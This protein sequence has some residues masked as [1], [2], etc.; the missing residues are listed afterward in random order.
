MPPPGSIAAQ[1]QPPPAAERREWPGPQEAPPRNKREERRSL[2]RALKRT[3]AEE[4]AEAK[5][6]AAAAA[7]QA[8]GDAEAEAAAGADA[9][10]SQAESAAA[11]V[12]MDAS[13]EGEAVG[14]AGGEGAA[15]GGGKELGERS[16]A[17]AVSAATGDAKPAE[18]ADGRAAAGGGTPV[19][20]ARSE[21]SSSTNPF[22]GSLKDP[23]D[24]VEV[25]DDDKETG[26]PRTAQERDQQAE[27][28]CAAARQKQQQAGS[29]SGAA[30]AAAPA[31]PGG[32]T[33]GDLTPRDPAQQRE[34]L[35]AYREELKRMSSPQ[36][37][38]QMGIMY[39]RLQEQ[40]TLSAEGHRRIEAGE[41]TN[42]ARAADV[43][44]T[45]AAD[46]RVSFLRLQLLQIQTAIDEAQPPARADAPPAD[47][48]PAAATGAGAAA[49]SSQ[50]APPAGDEGG[51]WQRMA[52]EHDEQPRRGARTGRARPDATRRARSGAG[53]GGR[54]P[55]PTKPV[56][57]SD[58]VI[59]QP[60]TIFTSDL[61]PDA[62]TTRLAELLERLDDG[63]LV[64]FSV[65]SELQ[66]RQFVA[67]ALPLGLQERPVPMFT[68]QYQRKPVA[69]LNARHKEYVQMWL[70]VGHQCCPLPPHL[71]PIHTEIGGRL[72]FGHMATDWSAIVLG[73]LPEPASQ[74]GLIDTDNGPSEP[75]LRFHPFTHPEDGPRCSYIGYHPDVAT[76]KYEQSTLRTWMALREASLS[77]QGLS[78]GQ[79]HEFRGLI[80]YLAHC[81]VLY[82]NSFGPECALPGLIWD[83]RFVYAE[84]PAP[85]RMWV[86]PVTAP[87]AEDLTPGTDLYSVPTPW[88]GPFK[89]YSF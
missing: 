19:V 16:P 89:F 74:A 32:E 35:G 69:G 78:V 76:P 6:A 60:Q 14:A 47:A 75:A 25:S 46:N 44:L 51:S 10:V 50:Q 17:A 70:Q 65:E 45:Q 41:G 82:A 62:R 29:S 5:A 86:R 58:R 4:E 3:R 23:R 28:A 8:A 64:P 9:A 31:V 79:A 55:R 20:S 11:D 39:K 22:T 21:G 63:W 83:P 88:H 30:S 54:W 42:L 67:Q 7:T 33:S 66:Q 13:A 72:N 43:A 71:A 85:E 27:A 38:E 15:D 12:D 52:D 40:L 48:Q 36:L 24:A 37:L 87:L 53:G 73:L 57:R 61:D 1:E 59:D 80:A 18:G 81:T 2:S 34:R 26:R 84:P 56:P 77:Q 49:S 68:L